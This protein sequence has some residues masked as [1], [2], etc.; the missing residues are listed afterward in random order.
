MRLR[1]KLFITV[2]AA[3]LIL[4]GLAFGY[5]IS[6]SSEALKT[7]LLESGR[8]RAGLEAARIASRLDKAAVESRLLSASVAALKSSGVSDRSFLP[9]LFASILKGD[10]DFFG[11]W[12][13]FAA[14]AWDGKD[15]SLS[16]DPRYAPTGAYIPW[17]FREGGKVKVLAGMAADNI[18][19][20]YASDYYKIPTETGKSLF[21]EPYV[22]TTEDGTAVQMTTFAL[23]MRD[24][25]GKLL[26][27]LGIDFSLQFLGS[28]FAG[29][30]SDGSYA[31]LLSSGL[32]ILADQKDPSLAGKPLSGLDGAKAELEKAASVSESGSGLV[33]ND[34]EGGK[35]VVRILASIRLEGDSK[36][37][38]YALSIPSSVLF[39]EM[40]RLALTMALAFILA[41]AATGAGVFYLSSSLT[42]P[43]AALGAV[44]ARME[45]GDLGVRLSGARSRDEVG[46]LSRA[47]NLFAI[48]MSALV[49]G[50]RKASADIEA[51]SSVLASSIGRSGDC[52]AEINKGIVETLADLGSQESALSGSREGTAAIIGAIAQLEDTIGLQTDSINEAAASV[53]EMVGNIQSL[54]KGSE[55]ISAEIKALDRSGA[56]GR[57]RLDAVLAAIGQAVEKSAYLI[58]ANKVIASVAS[59]TNLLAMNAAIEAAHAGEAGRGFAVV[60]QEIR[61][62]AENAQAQSKA[63]AKSGA[64]IGA[65]IGAASSSSNSA[66]EAFEAIVDRI[67]SVSRLED[68]AFAALSEQRSGG[69]LVLA[70]LGRMRDATRLVGASGEAMAEAGTEVESAMKSLSE[71]SAR[72]RERAQEIAGG[73]DRIEASSQESLL[74]SKANE[75]SVS[76]LRSEVARFRE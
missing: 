7:A 47:F 30:S 67:A 53:E 52:A 17:A 33:F 56:E 9:T 15:S 69:E 38:V 54:G 11:I 57:E 45:D 55:T 14:N 44:F 61:V 62:L 24:G 71:A 37:W 35:D 8:A 42:K 25:S 27:A 34:V 13:V 19:G 22:D 5:L 50:I 23:P 58:E 40:R 26:G 2:T 72:V 43:L 48:S 74:L 6:K 64:E 32:S 60:A 10:E 59:R 73:A 76:V 75:E 51:S 41:L 28:L 4:F 29:K 16:R 70:T 3:Q 20:D 36:A 46:E 21:L 39:L 65:A 1:A 63:I 12:A 68:E 49:G 18:G 66:R 31:R